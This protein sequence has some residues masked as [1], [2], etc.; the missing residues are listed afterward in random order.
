MYKHKFLSLTLTGM[1][2]GSLIGC[3]TYPA[4]TQPS[5]NQLNSNDPYLMQAQLALASYHEA[6]A[7]FKDSQTYASQNFQTKLLNGSTS[8]SSSA[9]GS[10]S[11][12]QGSVDGSL[13]SSTSGSASTDG[14]S[15]DGSVDGSASGSASTSTD[16]SS[17]DTSVSG[18]ASTSTST[19]SNGSSSSS[20]NGS[21]SGSSNTS[22][23]T[24]TTVNADANLDTD[25]NDID[26]NLGD[27]SGSLNNSAQITTQIDTLFDA[28][29]S[30]FAN[31]NAAIDLYNRAFGNFNSQF[32]GT[33]GILLDSQN[34]LQVNLNQLK[35]DVRADLQNDAE[36]SLTS[37]DLNGQLTAN[38]HANLKLNKLA[39]LG[40]SGSSSNIV[41]S[42]QA[43][44]STEAMLLTFRNVDAD[45][46]NRVRVISK[47]NASGDVRNE[48]N[49]RLVTDSSGF[50]RT[51]LREIIRNAAGHTEVSTDLSMQLDNGTQI[52][53]LE[54]RFVNAQGAGTG[55]G[56]FSITTGDG[57]QWSGTLRTVTSASGNLMLMLEPSGGSQSRLI[58][59]EKANG[60]AKLTLFNSQGQ[61][62]GSSELNMAA[63]ADAMVKG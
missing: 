40:Y 7:S 22:T 5:Q 57:T 10:A 14:G 2:C 1:L 24:T 55:L 16:S 35:S 3:S 31:Y 56:S 9:E 19:S 58:L 61:L 27:L 28:G 63:E 20:V 62:K 37:M 12:Q 17:G 41:S 52:N 45:L 59:Q 26:L 13:S 47:S 34:Q 44:A 29:S 60:N 33:A 51:G 48:V 50:K 8:L 15:V 23:N 53:L 49:L 4:A 46:T 42:G 6:D 38:T 43:G 25:A 39:K 21:V 30:S 54:K 11:T 36:L 32:L 18:S